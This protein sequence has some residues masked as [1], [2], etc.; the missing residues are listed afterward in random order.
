MMS[1]SELCYLTAIE[2]LAM[3]RSRKLSPV[4]LM[5]AVIERAEASNGELTAFTFTFFEEALDLAR[6]AEARYAGGGETGALEGLPVGI[7]DENWVA[8]KP[9]SFGT[10]IVGDY[11][12]D[13]TSPNNERIFQAGGIMHAKT[14]T[15]EYSITPY[16]NSRRWGVTRN[17]WNPA[18]TPGGSSGGAAASLAIGSS[19]LAMGSDI[20]GS[21]RIPASTC[22]LVGY[23]PPYGRNPDDPPF[24]LDAYC[25]TGPLGRSVADVALLQNVICGPHPQDISTLSPKIEVTDRNRSVKDWKIAYS[26]DLGYFEVDDEVRRNTLAALDVF[27]SMGAT[28]VEVDLGWTAACYEAAM[29]HLAHIFGTQMAELLPQHRGLMSPYTVDFA[30]AGARSTAGAFMRAMEESCRM[31]ASF[32]PMIAAHDVFIC[33]TTALPAV[34]A[35]FDHSRDPVVINGKPSPLTPPMLAWV[36]TTPFNTLSRCP[37]LAVP[38]GRA[39]TGVPT[40][41]QIVGKPYADQDVFDAGFAYERA[42]GGWFRAAEQRPAPGLGSARYARN[43]IV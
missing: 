13:R 40:G 30:E 42:L 10:L 14:T 8:G 11:I 21:I 22:G 41:I 1:S 28:L 33:P 43:A 17:P 6:K 25:H 3:F 31:Y 29:A 7:K 4:E 18:F 39:S 20:G 16:T 36:M 12:A 23:K 38:S 27:R 35:D 34:P 9:T 2:A 37:V 32:G 15:P 26:I 19:T 5:R 24:H